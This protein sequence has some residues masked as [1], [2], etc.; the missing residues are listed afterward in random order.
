MFTA[1]NF[2]K[3]HHFD[4]GLERKAEAASHCLVG[5]TPLKKFS[6]IAGS[7]PGRGKQFGNINYGS[8]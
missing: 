2:S 4:V 8:M 6:K 1:Y 5:N 7:K 3:T